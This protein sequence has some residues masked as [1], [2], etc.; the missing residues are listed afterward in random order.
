MFSFILHL[1]PSAL[2]P[3]VMLWRCVCV[4]ATATVKLWQKGLT[5]RFVRAFFNTSR[6]MDTVKRQKEADNS[7]MSNYLRWKVTQD[8]VVRA[9]LLASKIHSSKHRKRKRGRTS[10]HGS[11]W[12]RMNCSM[13]SLV[14]L[15][16]LRV[17]NVSLRVWSC[18]ASLF[19]RQTTSSLKV[20]SYTHTRKIYK[21]HRHTHIST[22]TCLYSSV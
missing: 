10:G 9:I 22:H 14:W 5:S 15:E 20:C 21:I 12:L 17:S 16:F 8:T 4:C 7:Y 18:S 19:L 11:H 13:L 6:V 2:L 1:Q 3:P